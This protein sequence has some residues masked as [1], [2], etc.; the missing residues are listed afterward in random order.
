MKT[1]K[2]FLIAFNILIFFSS[3][4]NAQD[5]DNPEKVIHT[6]DGFQLKA[7]HLYAYA[8]KEAGSFGISAVLDDP[9]AI[10]ALK[11]ELLEEF[12]SMSEIMIMELNEH[13]QW[14]QANNGK[15]TA[16]HSSEGELV[17]QSI[18]VPHDKAKSLPASNHADLN[19]W[20]Q[21]LNGS[22]LV[23]TTSQ[24]HGGMYVQST[25]YVHLC[26]GGNLRIYERSAGGGSASGMSISSS[27][28]LQLSV[29]G[30]WDVVSHGGVTYFRMGQNGEIA[31]TVIKIVNNQ[32]YLQGVGAL[33]YAPGAAECN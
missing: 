1:S 17:S 15:N 2:L 27:E 28:G 13:Y 16:N 22:V 33:Q 25:Q 8:D 30:Q 10:A 31:A 4:T 20:N 19:Q 12:A 29:I 18:G 21:L 7:K 3:C 32:I 14:M 5:F 11:T 24:H 23:F 9:Q 6:V 26:P